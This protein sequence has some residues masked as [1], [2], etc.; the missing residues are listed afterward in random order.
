MTG[1]LPGRNAVHAFEAFR[2]SSGGKKRHE[3]DEVR[4]AQFY[5]ISTGER[6]DPDNRATQQVIDD[7]LDKINKDGY[8]SLT[9]EEK[10]ILA[11]ASKRIH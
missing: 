2:M 9:E 3:T 10:R 1:R 4:E 7:I 11:E 6:T 5:D 8:Q